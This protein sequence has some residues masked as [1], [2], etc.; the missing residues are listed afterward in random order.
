MDAARG[1]SSALRLRLFQLGKLLHLDLGIFGL[2]GL[3]QASSQL[4][5]RTGILRL[6]FN[7]SAQGRRSTFRV[8]GGYHRLS[9][10]IKCI[11]IL[12]I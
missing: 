9:K 3:L 7:G 6:Q 11:S 10:F 12:R 2:S 8:A 1:H 4:V 5:M